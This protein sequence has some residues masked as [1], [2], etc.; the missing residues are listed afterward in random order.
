MELSPSWE[1]GNSAATE[2]L[3]SVLWNP[4]VHFRV[5]KSPLLVP[6]L[7]QINPVITILSFLPK[8]ILI[9][10]I[11][12]RIGRPGGLFP[13]GFP[14]N[15][16][17]AFLFSPFRATCPVNLILLDLIILIIFGEEYKLWGYLSN[18]IN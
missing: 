17:Y 12:L 6:I 10:S 5:H 7:N 15:I 13:S 14:T 2:Q 9:L 4:K 3:P 8:I 16:L 11:Y 1:A 18:T